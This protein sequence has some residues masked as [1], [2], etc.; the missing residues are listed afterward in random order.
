MVMRVQKP[1]FRQAKQAER[2]KSSLKPAQHLPLQWQSCAN[3]LKTPP[4][5]LSDH[6]TDS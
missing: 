1:R 5:Y 2:D 3:W 4:H 6:A